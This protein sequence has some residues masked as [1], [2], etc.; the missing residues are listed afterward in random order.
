MKYTQNKQ[1]KGIFLFNKKLYVSVGI[2]SIMLSGIII[3]I[4]TCQW[5]KQE[6]LGDVLWQRQMHRLIILQQLYDVWCFIKM[7]GGRSCSTGPSVKWFASYLRDTAFSVRIGDCCSSPDPFNC[8]IPQGP[9]LGPLL[10]TIFSPYIT[11]N[12]RLRPFLMPNFAA[13]QQKMKHF[14]LFWKCF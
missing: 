1:T 13:E 11:G 2:L 8:G 12:C 14:F 10:F 9:I 7:P 3:T 5:Q 6:L 4:W